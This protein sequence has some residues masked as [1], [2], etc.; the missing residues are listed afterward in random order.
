MTVTSLIYVLE[1]L[2]PEP[3]AG[4]L[5][6]I[7]FGTKATLDPTLKQALIKSG[8]IHMIALSGQNIVILIS[9]A[10][11]LL[12]LPFSRRIASLLMVLLLVGYVAFVGVSPSVIRAVL[13][14][15]IGLFAAIVGRAS[16][17]I[18]T[19][20]LAVSTMIVL[21]PSW[22]GDIGFQLSAVASLGIILFGKEPFVYRNSKG[23]A[24]MFFS[25]RSVI[26]SDLRI[27]LAAQ[28]LTIPLI[29]WYFHRISLLAP[30]TNVLV[31]W[32]M[33]PLMALGW[34]AAAAGSLFLPAGQILAWFCW[35][36]LEWM[37]RVVLFIDK[38]PFA[39]VGW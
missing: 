7:L 21:N 24:G 29:L 22:I 4:L 6:G 11:P 27:T 13:M 17:S 37:I 8:V 16:W 1:Q 2:L 25:L 26:E 10:T 38:I 5:A 12:V 30:I 33:A 36:L 28:S 35:V 15:S 9:I 14:G 32:T 31:G 20:I 39:S 23:I 34:L 3:H 18:L 19:W